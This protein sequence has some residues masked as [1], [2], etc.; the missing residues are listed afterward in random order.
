MKKEILGRLSE[1]INSLDGHNYKEGFS[2]IKDLLG[3]L[4]GI[5]DPTTLDELCEVF[6]DDYMVRGI[7]TKYFNSGETSLIN[8]LEEYLSSSISAL[9]GEKSDESE[10]VSSSFTTEF[11]NIINTEELENMN[12]EASIKDVE[13]TEDGMVKALVELPVADAAKVLTE[14]ANDQTLGGDVADELAKVIISGDPKADL[15]DSLKPVEDKVVQIID[16]R[17]DINTESFSVAKIR[18]YNKYI[19]MFSEAVMD[20]AIVEEVASECCGDCQEEELCPPEEIPEK[21]TVVETNGTLP[22]VECA[23]EASMPISYV[24]SSMV[25]PGENEAV[26]ALSEVSTAI[27]SLEQEQASEALGLIAEEIGP[28]AAEAIQGEVLSQNNPELFSSFSK[29]S[30]ITDQ[31]VF[32]AYNVLSNYFSGNITNFSTSEGS[33]FKERFMSNFSTAISVV[34][35]FSKG[36]GLN[37]ALSH[38]LKKT[39]S[40]PDVGMTDK[41]LFWREISE[42]L[43]GKIAAKEQEVAKLSSLWEKAATGNDKD[44]LF[45][46]LKN[47]K[48]QLLAYRQQLSTSLT[49]L[50]RSLDD[51]V[52]SSAEMLSNIPSRGGVAG[53]MGNHPIIAGTTI[54]T[55]G[56]AAALYGKNLLDKR[57]K[58]MQEINGEFEGFSKK[59]NEAG[60]YFSDSSEVMDEVVEKVLDTNTIEESAELISEVAERV[61]PEIALAIQAEACKESSSAAKELADQAIVSEEEIVEALEVI[62]DV[63]ENG[64]QE[65]FSSAKTS[66]YK[67]FMSNFA[68][69]AEEMI[70][71]GDIDVEDLKDLDE[72]DDEEEEDEDEGEEILVNL[73][74]DGKEIVKESPEMDEIIEKFESL[75]AV[76]DAATLLVEIEDEVGPEAALAVQSELL[77][78]N[79]DLFEELNSQIVLDDNVVKEIYSIVKGFNPEAEMNFSEAGMD[80]YSVYVRNFAEALS[81]QDKAAIVEEVKAQIIG[82]MAGSAPAPAPE[83]ELPPPPA[84]P[85][86]EVPPMPAP[87]AMPL[88][89]V[90]APVPPMAPPAP[91]AMPIPEAIPA[92]ESVPAPVQEMPIQ[93][94]VPSIPPPGMAA[95]PQAPVSVEYPGQFIPPTGT[96]PIDAASVER[97]D[98]APVVPNLVSETLPPPSPFVTEEGVSEIPPMP[99]DMPTEAVVT[100]TTGEFTPSAVNAPKYVHLIQQSPVEQM[101]ATM[102]PVEPA[103]GNPQMPP[104]EQLTDVEVQ[105][106][107]V[108]NF[109]RA[110]RQVSFSS[111]KDSDIEEY[112]KMMLGL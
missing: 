87:E 84:V 61:S 86:E 26:D 19:T 59:L 81:D 10:E 69:I 35:N 12:K 91:E 25:A 38:F 6:G 53:F 32:A 90:E 11:P 4:R 37:N 17:S 2:R 14:I 58:N 34:E 64:T 30:W 108:D 51:S 54:G 92:P 72:D 100:S 65:T 82:E 97:P 80:R 24:D 52:I 99:M 103:V 39:M 101:Q 46:E 1:I 67:A 75:P 55:G 44:R 8:S 9:D 85:V 31:E 63:L 48:E 20:D 45:R 60:Y 16:T 83:G 41:A 28:E 47:A 95:A 93:E 107:I 70:E 112:Q 98:I 71:N 22:T 49:S 111:T 105:K 78:K 62:N 3:Q 106:A 66:F 88:P 102:P 96:A 43:S 104:V 89:P 56:A 42:N 94:E 23:H 68:S 76:E 73:E 29:N 15:A 57:N 109:S 27:G 18:S 110:R 36:K 7:L 21:T 50:E 79:S 40:S 5:M 13:I 33:K 77:K 74:Q